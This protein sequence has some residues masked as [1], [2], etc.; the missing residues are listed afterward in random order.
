M[1]T[2]K[3]DHLTSPMILA[4]DIGG[5]KLLSAVVIVHEDNG[6][7]RA[8]LAGIAKRLLRKDAGQDGVW[9]ALISAVDET[10]ETAG[11]GLNEITA[12]GLTI[13]GVADPKRGYWVFAPF[14]GISD[15]PIGDKLAAR[16]D[17]PVF[18][19]NDVNACAWGEKIFGV[20]Q[21]VDDFLWITISNGI[22]G[23]L[24]LNG[25]IYP[26][27]F[28]GAAEIGHFKVVEGGA[29]CG[30]GG[31][32]CLEATASGLGIA[33]AYREHVQ[34]AIQGNS[35]LPSSL[36]DDWKNYLSRKYQ[37]FWESETLKLEFESLFSTDA[38][39]I[40]DE[41]RKG[42]P[43]AIAT[44]RE[45]GGFVGRAASWAAN[46]IN[47]EKIVIGGGV[48]GAFELFYPALWKKFEECVFKQA[49]RSLTI[50]KT[51]L[52]YEA[53]LKGAASLAYCNPYK[54]G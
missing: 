36:L 17:K 52:G 31:R 40:A 34:K 2:T 9:T 26:G 1:L 13:P 37:N 11:V 47:P 50:E 44:Y 45:M 18:A 20:C 15:F 24:I 39:L 49:N 48:A 6:E 21:E 27:K 54:E 46:L 12:I 4:L 25:R 53:G 41:A 19:D 22:G 10:F 30:C 7:R 42:N 23:G 16:Y 32:G 5:S 51:G 33:R 35:S 38:A 43:I 29:P 28:L 14:S 3:N 8:T